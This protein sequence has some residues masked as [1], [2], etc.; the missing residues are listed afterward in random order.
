IDFQHLE[1]E[2]L[3]ENIKG[4]QQPQKLKVTLSNWLVDP[5]FE[6]KFNPGAKVLINGILKEVPV[7]L[8][9]G[10]E[11]TSYTYELEAYY[12]ENIDDE[13]VDLK[14]SD[15]DMIRI[16]DIA[17]KNDYVEI[18]KKSFAP[19]IYGHDDI[20]EGLII[21]IVSG[22]RKK[23]DDGTIKRGDIHILMIGDP[24]AG[25]S[26][27]LGRVS[28]LVPSARQA[29][30][31]GASGVGLTAATIKDEFLGGWTFQAGTLVLSHRTIAIVDEFDK[32]N[33][34]DRDHMHE[35]LEQQ[36]VTISKA[37]VQ[38]QLRCECSLLAGANPKY[39]RFDP[40][41]KTIAEQIDL[42]PTLINRFDLIFA[43][44]DIPDPHKDKKI[45]ERILK[46]HQ[47]EME[48]TVEIETTLLRKY[49]FLAKTY[50]PIITDEAK[51][52]LIKYYLKIRNTGQT[53][54]GIK[55]I[56]LN[57]RQLEALIRMSEAFAKLRLSKEVRKCDANKAISILDK[58]LRKIA[59][60]EETGTIDID[61]IS[62]GLTSNKRNNI[63]IVKQI[64]S[65]LE[66]KIGKVIP[67]EDLLKIASDKGIVE[68]QVDD[69]IEELK[70]HG[71]LFETKKGFLSRL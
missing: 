56:P 5:S 31:K 6:Q 19:S 35:A 49:L 18:L 70:H 64:I 9:T 20:I 57:A 71:D 37:G 39:S 67:I 22:V 52:E 44:Q 12:I 62:T 36:T 65:D 68:H 21:Q 14:I 55:A 48:C 42:P 41:A 61:R 30:G 11:S 33:K 17:Q 60:D 4:T 51:R 26:V 28:T 53:E 63:S 16:K 15:Q 45:A 32:M 50:N 29:N 10:A 58:C 47:Q 38:A 13:E 54:S 3:P 69:A 40:Y 23:K 66:N 46:T 1:L 2:E 34:D 27:L 24:G 43:V 8:K 7:I 59:F 25:K